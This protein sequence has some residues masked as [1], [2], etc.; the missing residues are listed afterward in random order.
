MDDTIF[1]LVKVTIVTSHR[2]IH[3]AIAELQKKSTCIIANTKKV[4]VKKAEFMD[5]KLKS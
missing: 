2:N 5:Y 1:L 4:R 3:E